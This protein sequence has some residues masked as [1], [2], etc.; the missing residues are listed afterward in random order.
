MPLQLVEGGEGVAQVTPEGLLLFEF[1][2]SRFHES[3]VVSV[4]AGRY[5]AQLPA[6][7]A[8]APRGNWLGLLHMT[9]DVSA[10]PR[11]VT[12]ALYGVVRMDDG[13]GLIS[14]WSKLFD[15]SFEEFAWQS[16]PVRSRYGAG[17]YAKVIKGNA[18]VRLPWWVT[19]EE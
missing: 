11:D 1:P 19:R 10:L 9:A 5:G 4:P 15:G 16:P 17:F 18:A 14:C 8:P 6:A 12:L 3:R 13:G 7:A 2:H